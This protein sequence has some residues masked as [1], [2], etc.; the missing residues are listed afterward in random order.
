M[1]LIWTEQLAVGYGLIDTQHQELFARYNRLLEACK[2][3]KGREELEPVLDFL[4]EYVVGHFAEEE[5]FMQRYAYP[6]RDDHVAQHR[7]LVSKVTAVREELRERGPTV[8]VI[9]SINQTLCN[10]LIGHVKQTDVKLGRFL[11][12]RT[13]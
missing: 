10:W 4:I 6:E 11:A 1:A 9:T 13:T 12:A 8:A 7:E 2:A 5:H 3:G